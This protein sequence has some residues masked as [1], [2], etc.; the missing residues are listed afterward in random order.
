MLRNEQC[1]N[2][3]AGLFVFLKKCIIDEGQEGSADV[4]PA[5]G[6]EEARRTGSPPPP[7]GRPALFPAIYD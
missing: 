2:V 7:A 4:E 1:K 3:N 5:G 6:R